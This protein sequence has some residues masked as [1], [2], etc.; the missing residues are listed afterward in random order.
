MQLNYFDLAFKNNEC[1]EIIIER[2]N[3]TYTD[4]FALKMSHCKT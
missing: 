1:F 4:E 3:S 2:L